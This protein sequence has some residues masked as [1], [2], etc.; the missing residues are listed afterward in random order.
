MAARSATS[1]LTVAGGLSLTGNNLP[2][3]LAIPLVESSA[4]RFDRRPHDTD[5]KAVKPIPSVY[6]NLDDSVHNL[7]VWNFTDK[8]ARNCHPQHSRKPLDPCLP[9]TVKEIDEGLTRSGIAASPALSDRNAAVSGDTVP[10]LLKQGDRT[11]PLALVDS[12]IEARDDLCGVSFERLNDSPKGKLGGVVHA[13]T[14]ARLF[15][16]AKRER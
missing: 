4:E 6:G 2:Q 8:Q 9:L 16:P 7:E 13:V 12:F 5:R 15:V 1:R 14:F 10:Q 11:G 3:L